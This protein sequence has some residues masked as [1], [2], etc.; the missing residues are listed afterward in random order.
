MQALQPMLTANYLLNCMHVNLSQDSGPLC[1]FSR[2]LRD[3]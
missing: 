1:D 3:T 2:F